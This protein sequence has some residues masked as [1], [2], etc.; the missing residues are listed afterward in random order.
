MLVDRAN[1]HRHVLYICVCVN[2][3]THTYTHS[4][5]ILNIYFYICFYIEK[6]WFTL[7]PILIFCPIC[8]SFLWYWEISLPLL[9]MHLL[10]WPI[11]LSI[12]YSS[13]PQLYTQTHTILLTPIW[14]L[15]P[16]TRPPTTQYESLLNSWQ[17]SMPRVCTHPHGH[18]LHPPWA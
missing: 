12:T 1:E 8:N 5:F 18:P 11:P 13:F 15:K 7:K 6:H 17:V 10:I 16:C 4:N 9:E 14:A 2:T 3:Q